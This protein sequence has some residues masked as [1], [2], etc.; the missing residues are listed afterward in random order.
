MIHERDQYEVQSTMQGDKIAMTIDESSMAHIMNVLTDLYSNKRRAIIREYST[1]A[2]DAHVEAGVND[3]I[4]VTLPTLLSPFLKVRDYGVGLTVEDIH[5]IYSQ[6]GASTKRGTNA[7]NGMLGLGCKSALT[8]TQQFTVSS[9]KDG[10]KIVVSVGRDEDGG[11]SMTVVDTRTT[12]EG[13]GTEVVIPIN[14]Q[15]MDIMAREAADFFAVWKRGTVRVNGA[16]PQPII[17][18]DDTMKLTDTL[19]VDRTSSVSR[20]VMGNVA[21]PAPALDGL[22]RGGAILAFVPIGSVNF[23]PS[24]EALMDTK[25]T[26]ATIER[27][28]GEVVTALKGA[29]QREVSAAADP[30]AALRVVIEWSRTIPN[31][32]VVASDYTYQGQPLPAGYTVPGFDKSKPD[33][34]PTQ[35]FLLTSSANGYRKGYANKRHTWPVQE[36]PHTVWVEDF[37]ASSYTAQHKNRTIKWCADQ[38]ITDAR[39]FVYLNGKAPASKFIPRDRVVSWDVLKKLK[40]QT[41]TTRYGSVRLAGSYDFVTEAGDHI[42]KPGSDI[43]QDK[44]L[45]YFHGNRWEVRAYTKGL[46]AIHPEFT[47]VCLAAN[48]I[49]KFKRENPKVKK[50][51]DAFVDAFAKWKGK[52]SQDERDAIYVRM[53][54]P[55]HTLSRLDPAKV[56]DPALKRS[57]ALV[58]RKGVDKLKDEYD[59]LRFH[60]REDGLDHKWTNPLTNYPLFNDAALRTMPDHVYSYL[61]HTYKTELAGR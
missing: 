61:N 12:D 35:P 51:Q 48:R 29:I 54:G 38:G 47:V 57:V 6:Y 3:P 21:Y 50:V 42:G 23:P 36:W 31:A 13:N 18:S 11:G 58:T 5:S 4:D 55:H 24:R 59:A 39:E 26:R 2:F 56:E 25:S 46:S 34:D 16:E 44:P 1:N 15:D 7:Q 40:M 10:T 33:Y 41:T 45:Y 22:V 27:V 32:S 43:R 49:D 37:T 14:R 28:K 9:I 8:Y 17:E 20:V 52:L 53:W 60:V 19:F 30:V